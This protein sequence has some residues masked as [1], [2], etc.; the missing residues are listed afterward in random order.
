MRSQEVQ[1]PK[2]VEDVHE[3]D[4]DSSEKSDATSSSD[5]SDSSIEAAINGEETEEAIYERILAEQEGRDGFE[6]HKREEAG[7]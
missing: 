1:S 7:P 3:E 5:S 6:E 2:I 4:D